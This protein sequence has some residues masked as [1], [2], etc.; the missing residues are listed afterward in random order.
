MALAAA[1]PL[2]AAEGPA[3]PGEPRGAAAKG[4]DRTIVGQENAV[5]TFAPAVPPPIQRTN[6]TKVVVELEVKEVVA[7]LAD[8]VDY[9]FWTFGGE[10][11]G[12]VI[13]VREG[14]LVEFHL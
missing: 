9:L 4:V 3:T 5:L 6:A 14:D 12:K 13:R 11:H 8:G 1:L 2:A 10:V 7:K